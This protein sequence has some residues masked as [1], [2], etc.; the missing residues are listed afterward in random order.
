[1]T[2]SEIG[3]ILDIQR[4]NMVPLLNRLDNAGLISRLPIDRKSQAIVLTGSG[5][6]RLAEVKAITSQFENDLL[7]RIPPQHR[8]HLVPALR[9]LIA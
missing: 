5:S 9:A 8:P 1:M 7:D 2:S 3:K 4:A 6:Q